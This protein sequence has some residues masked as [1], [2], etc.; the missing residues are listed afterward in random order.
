MSSQTETINTKTDAYYEARAEYE[1]AKELSDAAHKKWRR[2]EAE[3]VDFMLEQGIKKFSRDDGTTPLLA[4]SCTISCTK[5]NFDDIREWL[6]Q[7]I[8][9]DADFVTEVVDKSALLELV[10]KRI[11][12]DMWDESDFPEFLKVNTRPTL[13]VDGWAKR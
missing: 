2:A 10:K 7:D 8:G 4:R 6:R 9:D 12:E 13:R 3:L 5:G 11:E 1:A